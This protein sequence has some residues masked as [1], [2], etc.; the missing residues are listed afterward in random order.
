MTGGRKLVLRHL[1]LGASPCPERPA[2]PAC[3]AVARQAF[4]LIELLVVIAIV[5]ILAAILFPVF[6]RVRENARRTVCASNLK[7]LGLAWQMYADDYDEHACPSYHLG[8]ADDAWDFHHLPG[9]AWTTGFLGVYTRDGEV[10]GCPDNPFKTT[11]SN[12]PYNG[13]GYNATY[14]GGDAF[15]SPGGMTIYPACALPQ[16]MLP[17]QTAVFSDAGYGPQSPDNFL[18]APSEFHS[19]ANSGNTDF[20]HSLT[21][22]VCYA[23]GHVKSVHDPAPYIAPGHSNPQWGELSVDDSAYGPGMNPCAFYALP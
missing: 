11:S 17:S 16:I 19:Y 1:N 6:S 3:R 18:R 14:I 22:N 2:L 15:P 8:N 10:H 20:R 12:R 9:G 5:S 7:Q 4:T 23:D 21:A 13:Y